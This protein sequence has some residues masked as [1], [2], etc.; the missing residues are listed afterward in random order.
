MIATRLLLLGA[1]VI[2]LAGPGRAF[3]IRARWTERVP[4]SAILLW[5]ATG[6]AI[7]V[8]LIGIC[9]EVARAAEPSAPARRTVTDFNAHTTAASSGGVS[10]EQ[11]FALTAALIVATL[12]FGGVFARIVGHARTRARQR[13]LIDLVGR[14]RPQLP[15]TLVLPSA[16]ATA[17]SLP[18]LR[19]RVVIS[20]GALDVLEDD[21]LVAVLAH[22]RAHV[23]ARHDLAVLPFAALAS[24]LP[25][26]RSLARVR[27][28]IGALVEMAADDRVLHQ[29]EPTALARALCRLAISTPPNVTLGATTSATPRRVERVLGVSRPAR[30]LA[31]GSAVSAVAIVALPVL[32]LV[33][34]VAR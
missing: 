6:G 29:C 3:L 2:V 13:L 4:R 23:R 30:M 1:I 19:S 34:P 17:F 32:A 10:P 21:E 8:A 27:G 25:R 24:V 5:Q 12:A 9:V 18:G 7:A 20:T 16:H 15:G 22:E 31:S 28:E 11:L 14:E 33:L 26:S